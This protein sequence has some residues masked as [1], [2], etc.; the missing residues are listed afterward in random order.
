MRTTNARTAS[1][2]AE[3]E[4]QR[5]MDFADGALGAAGH[6][7]TDPVL[8]EL[9]RQVAAGTLSAD[10]AIERGIAYIDAR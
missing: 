3:A 5:R 2:V 1:H 4:A 9:S 7:V 8:N 6:G 10:D